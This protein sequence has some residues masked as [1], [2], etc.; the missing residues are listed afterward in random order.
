MASGI[1]FTFK[2]F[3]EMLENIGA[4]GGDINKAVN[5]AMKQSAQIVKKEM[6]AQMS[7][8]DFKAHKG[9]DKG[10]IK[11][12]PEPSIEWDGN[13]CTARVGYKKGAYN[14]E[15]ISDGY[16]AVF[17]N[18][19]TPKISPANFIQT[20]KKKAAAPVK[21]AQKQAFEKIMERLQ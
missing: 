16:K 20:T 17:L 14:P 13:R 19:G 6:K 5:S 18:Y 3:E 12:M 9:I 7:K 10:L 1:K 4:A 11:R 8:A 2:G 21:K 15:D